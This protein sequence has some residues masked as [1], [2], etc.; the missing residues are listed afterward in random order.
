MEIQV[1]IHY[2]VKN[3][4]E[5]LVVVI[6]AYDY[7]YTSSAPKANK[8]TLEHGDVVI[9]L[10]HCS[11]SRN[12]PILGYAILRKSTNRSLTCLL[13]ASKHP[14]HRHLLKNTITKILKNKNAAD[15]A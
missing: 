1:Q 4:I 8:L 9:L 3:N 7:Y 11:K 5:L 10:I 6:D 12:F 15:R 14:T 2:V 13:L